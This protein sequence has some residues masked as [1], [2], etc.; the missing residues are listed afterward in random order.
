MPELRRDSLT[1]QWVIIS[2]SRQHRPD[3]FREHERVDDPIRDCPFE[4]GHEDQTPPEVAA[5]RPDDG[6]T[7]DWRVRVVPNKFPALENPKGSVTLTA[8]GADVLP[9]KGAHEVVVETPD[10]SR[11]WPDFS[12]VQMERVLGMYVQRLRE[13]R[14]HEA[15]R[16]VQVFKNHGA[17]AG[18][19]LSHPHAQIVTLPLLP[20]RI[21]RRLEWA[22]SYYEAETRCY[23]CA[24][25]EREQ[26]QRDRIVEAT[27]HHLVWCP[28]ASRFPYEL[29]ILPRRHDHDLTGLT[30]AQR[31]DLSR[32]LPELT[33]RL[34]D[35]LGNPPFN[36]LVHTA[37][38]PNDEACTEKLPETYHWHLELVPRLSRTAG[39]ELATDVHLNPV[40]PETAAE[41]LRGTSGSP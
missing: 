33:G 17:R 39:L 7:D 14:N 1:D 24:G 28:Y 41:H 4:P 8:D 32:L 27:K 2:E 11:G 23:W 34:R 3:D 25:L 38:E 10:H 40:G 9:G 21:R 26:K 30:A 36:L 13:L 29:R 31:A 35:R 22:R 12:P 5:D 6:D 15:V 16:M 19:T 18:A 37:P 20:P